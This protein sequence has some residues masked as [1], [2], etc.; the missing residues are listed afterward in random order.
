MGIEN[1]V[2]ELGITV[3]ENKKGIERKPGEQK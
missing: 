1:E 2:R 3:S